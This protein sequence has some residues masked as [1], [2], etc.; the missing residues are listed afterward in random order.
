MWAL[1]VGFSLK[2]VIVIFYFII[3]MSTIETLREADSFDMEDKIKLAIWRKYTRFP[4][5]KRLDG[6]FS[7]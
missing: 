6:V 5:E 7:F 1:F 3:Q 4:K 2:C